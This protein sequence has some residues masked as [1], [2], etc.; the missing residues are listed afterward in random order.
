M[1]AAQDSGSWKE[2]REA[3]S[4]ADVFEGTQNMRIWGWASKLRDH[5][6]S[7]GKL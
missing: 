7:K 5:T 4:K 3:I 6:H 1:A 2:E